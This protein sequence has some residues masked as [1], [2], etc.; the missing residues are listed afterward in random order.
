MVAVPDE[1]P[2]RA[3]A[4]GDGD[5]S[6]L[7]SYLRSLPRRGSTT[8]AVT[9]ALREA[10][11]DGVL[12][13]ATWLREDELSRELQVSRTPIREALR[14]LS[15]E[16]LT[17]RAAN[18]G[19]LVSSM[20]LEDVLAVYVVRERLEGLAARIAATRRPEG[21]IQELTAL[22]RRMSQLADA[23]EVAGLVELNLQFHRLI[24]QGSGN[25]YLQRFL[26]QVEHAVRRFGRSTYQVPGRARETLAEHRAIIEAIAA[27]DPDAAEERAM[28][29]MRSARD[30]RVRQML[31]ESASRL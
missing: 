23:G 27:G 28:Q 31:D 29:H 22:H 16:G 8:D 30:V 26:T 1:M 9:D 19:T 14:R 10:I 24:R 17:S 5:R 6:P 7:R 13:Q 15:D 4:R 18:R 20:S 21:L 12:P 11:L 25:A 3:A 2:E